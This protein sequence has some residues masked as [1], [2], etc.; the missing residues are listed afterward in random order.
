MGKKPLDMLK[1]SLHKLQSQIQ[2]RKNN[3]LACLSQK[4]KLS[5]KDEEWLD[6]D[7]NLVNKEFLVDILDKASNYECKLATLDVNKQSLLQKLMGFG[8]EKS[9]VNRIQENKRV[10]MCF[11]IALI[12]Y[13][14]Q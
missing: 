1:S 8:M 12:P 14:K 6:H 9:D 10:H 3:L 7:A 4:E 11:L 5:P 13:T 2:D